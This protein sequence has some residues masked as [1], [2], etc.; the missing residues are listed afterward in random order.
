MHK[1]AQK[2]TCETSPSHSEEKGG[3][4]KARGNRKPVGYAGYAEDVWN[5]D[6]E[7]YITDGF[8]RTV[9]EVVKRLFW[10]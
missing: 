9:K 10:C 6:E 8:Y 5:K 7:A 1:H 2:D 4:E 3:D